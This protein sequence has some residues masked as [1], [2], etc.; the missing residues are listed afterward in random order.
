M[1][2]FLV[3]PPICI[4]NA[5]LYDRGW[6]PKKIGIE[7]GALPNFYYYTTPREGGNE[8]TGKKNPIRIGQ[9]QYIY[10]HCS[11]RGRAQLCI[12]IYWNNERPLRSS[13]LEI[14]VYTH[15][16]EIL[17]SLMFNHQ[18]CIIAS[19]TTRKDRSAACYY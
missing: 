8:N 14:L 17:R 9:G 3:I 19:P 16:L 5:T 7:R 18:I 1:L 4:N 11:R 2:L 6:V 13:P 12:Y 15:R 10:C